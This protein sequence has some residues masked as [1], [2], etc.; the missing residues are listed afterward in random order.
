[1]RLLRTPASCPT[2]NDV[3]DQ[4]GDRHVPGAGCRAMCC[5]SCPP[6]AGHRSAAPSILSPYGVQTA[7]PRQSD[8]HRWACVFILAV[9][10]PLVLAR[11]SEDR[12]R[13]FLCAATTVGQCSALHLIVRHR[14]T[15]S[16]SQVGS[17]AAAQRVFDLLGH[18]QYLSGLDRDRLILNQ[19][20]FCPLEHSIVFP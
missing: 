14:D 20:R 11:S 5:C 13:Q 3:V 9:Y 18:L 12:I 16:E 4:R 15:E 2:S 8:R 10:R 1:M 6:C 17:L 19:Q 7:R